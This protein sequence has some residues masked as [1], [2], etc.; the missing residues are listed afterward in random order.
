M[1]KHPV[2]TPKLALK[3]VAV[4]QAHGPDGGLAEVGNDIH[5]SNRILTNKGRDR[6]GAGGM[7]IQEDAAPQALK[8]G[9]TPTILMVVG[10]TAPGTKALKGETNIRRHIA[11][12]PQELTH[13]ELFLVAI[14]WGRYSAT[15]QQK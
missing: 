13:G 5:R 1:G 15:D 12:H 2:P 3:G 10:F 14:N 8:E 9:N 11:V 6:G 4:F 7:V